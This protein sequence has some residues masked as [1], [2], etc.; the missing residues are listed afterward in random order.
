MAQARACAREP[1]R[2]QHLHGRASTRGHKSCPAVRT[3]DHR[4]SSP[5]R[6]PCYDAPAA[7][8]SPAAAACAAERRARRRVAADAPRHTVRRTSGV[9]SRRQL[10]GT[11]QGPRPGWP[12]R[13]GSS[14]RARA[15]LHPSRRWRQVRLRPHASATGL[16]RPTASRTAR[17]LSSPPARQARLT[18]CLPAG[19]RRLRAGDL[20][21]NEDLKPAERFRGIATCLGGPERSTCRSRE[22]EA[23]EAPGRRHGCDGRRSGPSR[24]TPER[25]VTGSF[26]QHSATPF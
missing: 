7:G 22:G 5:D 16:R 9:S 20:R 11:G 10:D 8:T 17:P 25:Q 6:P 26:S 19:R 1:Y 14:T 13:S 23:C 12:E 4:S 18:A 2:L 3:I 24:K 21:G 15:W